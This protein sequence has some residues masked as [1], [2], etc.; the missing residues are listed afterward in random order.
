M[1]IRLKLL[2]KFIKF[3]SIDFHDFTKAFL[4]IFREL[5]KKLI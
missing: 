5:K 4:S 1:K 3:G 2:Y